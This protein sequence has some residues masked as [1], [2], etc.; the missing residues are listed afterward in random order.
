MDATHPSSSDDEGTEAH[1]HDVWRRDISADPQRG[2]D[3]CGR[4][5]ARYREKHRRYHDVE[6][7]AAVIGSVDE[8]AAELAGDLGDHP[9]DDLPAGSD[10]SSGAHTPIADRAAIVAAAMYH[11]A[12]YEPASNANERAS[13]RLAR[14]DL[15]EL[16]WDPARIERVTAMIEATATHADPPDGDHAVLFDADLAI[17]GSTAARY[18]RYADG[19]RSEYRHV[20]DVDWRSGRGDVLRTLLARESIFTTS[21]GRRR[22]EAAAR[23]NLERELALL[24]AEIRNGDGGDA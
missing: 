12:V 20:D 21:P 15:T 5:L 24:D 10:A 11:D 4:L 18:D 13:A 2:A 1:L 9:V 23:S 16:G 14:R 22:W 7:L 19:V 6:H 17:L 8:L 3:L